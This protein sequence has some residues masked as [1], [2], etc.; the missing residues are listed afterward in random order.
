VAV[1]T[2][3]DG[4]QGSRPRRSYMYQKLVCDGISDFFGLSSN[5]VDLSPMENRWVG[6]PI[7][8]KGTPS[9]LLYYMHLS[10]QHEL[11]AVQ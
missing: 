7:C 8:G 1:S 5:I 2:D 3:S 11:A 6:L 9:F 10:H 4:G